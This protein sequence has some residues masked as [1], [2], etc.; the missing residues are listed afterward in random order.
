V[1]NYIIRVYRCQKDN[2]QKFV[3]TVE[4]VGLKTKLSFTNYEELWE[5]L[6]APEHGIDRKK[7]RAGKNI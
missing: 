7:E 1:D 3:G 5:I 4:K 6:N 2:P